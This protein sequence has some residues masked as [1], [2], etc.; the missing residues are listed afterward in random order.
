MQTCFEDLEKL[1][2][3]TG[4]AVFRGAKGVFGTDTKGLEWFLAITI[5]ALVWSELTS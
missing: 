2:V 1:Y 3:Q 4:T 5:L